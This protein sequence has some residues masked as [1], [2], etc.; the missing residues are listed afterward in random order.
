VERIGHIEIRISGNRGNALVTPDNFDIREIREILEQT[1]RMLFPFEKKDRPLVTYRMDEGSV[2]NIFKTS[3][4][5]I[6]GFNAILGEIAHRQSVDFLDLP[7][8]R[9]FESF[10]E[11][12]IRKDY[13]F[14]INTSEQDSNIIQIN[15]TTR[16]LTNPAFWG[17][18]EFYY[19]GKITSLGGKERANIHIAT[20]DRGVVII[21]T[22]KEHLEK[23]EDNL[24]YKTY[25]IRAIGRQHSETGEVDTASLRFLELVEYDARY[26]EDYLQKLRE[27]AKKSWANIQDTDKWLRDLRGGYDA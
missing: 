25:G 5:Y 12:A 8:A 2:R 26:D 13:T 20:E 19:Y 4:Q 7:T 22:S 24:L 16:F 9:A 21:Q 17:E 11:M 1:E 23:L 15:K 14:D 27:K 6:I 18:A 3:L 10:Q